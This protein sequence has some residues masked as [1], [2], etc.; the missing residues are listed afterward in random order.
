MKQ[1]REALENKG[2]W[3]FKDSF[4]NEKISGFCLHDEHFP[5]IYINNSILK[6]RQIF[7]LFH[8]LAHLILGKGGISFRKNIESDLTGKYREEEVFCNAFASAFLVPDNSLNISGKPTDREISK[9]ANKYN[10][11]REVILRK[12]LDRKLINK[13]FYDEKVN[14]WRENWETQQQ[15]QKLQGKIV[16]VLPNL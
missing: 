2:Y 15:R 9:H 16:E 12:Y 11:S 10:V 5:L 8:E 4:Q 7:T 14:I 13:E 1:W 6:Q 3:V